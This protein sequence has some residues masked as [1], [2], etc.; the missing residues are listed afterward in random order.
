M[1]LTAL[2]ATNPPHKLGRFWSDA[3]GRFKCVYCS[4]SFTVESFRDDISLQEAKTSRLCQRCQ[5]F[6]YAD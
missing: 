3:H 1:P 2:P 5:D 6:A 4:K